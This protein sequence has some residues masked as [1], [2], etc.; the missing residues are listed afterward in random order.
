MKNVY[1]IFGS[2]SSLD[3]DVLVLIDQMPSLEDAKKLCN[4]FNNSL[5]NISS[6]KVNSNLGIVQDGQLLSVFKGTVDEVN[7]SIFDTYHLH[8]QTH[9]LLI[10]SRIPRDKEAKV[11][12]SMRGILSFL[13]RTQYREAVKNSLKNDLLHKVRT[14]QGIDLSKPLDLTKYPLTDIYKTI[15]FQMGQCQALLEGVELYTKESIADHY[16]KLKLFLFRDLKANLSDLEIAK[17][18]FLQHVIRYLPEMTKLYEDKW[19]E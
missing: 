3:L 17:Q 16:P 10:T 14:L 19:L 12:R 6:K 9:P 5:Q 7:N 2:K 15:S 11:L 13:S 8:N 1:Y 18:D 4:T